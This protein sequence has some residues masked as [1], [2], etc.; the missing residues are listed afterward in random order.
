MAGPA[1]VGTEK[2]SNEVASAL[3]GRLPPNARTVLHGNECYE[4]GRAHV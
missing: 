1:Q 4:I 3:A 2:A